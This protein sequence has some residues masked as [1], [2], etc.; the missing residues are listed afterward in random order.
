MNDD[1]TCIQLN[2]SESERFLNWLNQSNNF[3]FQTFSEKGK[4]GPAEQFSGTV[5]NLWSMLEFANMRQRGVAVTINETQGGRKGENVTRIRAVWQEDDNG[6]SGSFPLEPSIVV[7]S[8]V[9]KFHRYW[10]VDGDWPADDQGR[11]D[12]TAVMAT[13]VREYGS[14]PSAKDISRAM[15]LPGTLHQKGDPQIVSI[16][17]PVGS[18]PVRYTRQQIVSAFAGDETRPKPADAGRDTTKKAELEFDLARV[19]SA[20]SA[21][22]P[23]NH[24]QWKPTGMALHDAT[25]GSDDGLKIWTDWSMGTDRANFDMAEQI[26]QWRSFDLGKSVAVTLGTVFHNARLAG[27][28]NDPWAGA[29][30]SGT[31][32]LIPVAAPITSGTLAQATEASLREMSSRNPGFRPSTAQWLGLRDLAS[33]LEA[34]ANGTAEPLTYLSC[35]DP[36]VG[37]TQTVIRFTKALLR[38]P[39]HRDVAVLICVGRLEEIR[40]YVDSAG[41]NDTDYAVLVSDDPKNLTLKELGNQDRN[42][43]RVLFTTQQMLESRAKLRGSFSDISEFWFDDRPRRVRIWDEACL[44]ARPLAVDVSLIE[45]MT[46]AVKGQSVKLHAELKKLIRAIDDASD[47]S[48]VDV[49]D[50]EGSGVDVATALG[51]LSAE[52]RIIRDAMR[53][54]YLLSGKTVAVVK[55]GNNGSFVHYENTLPD[56]LKPYVVCDAS[57]RVRQTYPHWADGRGDL[58]ELQRATKDYSNLKVGLWQTSGSKSAWK[59]NASE[60][61]D[62]ITTTV[63]QEPDRSF[64]IVYHMQSTSVPIDI[65]AEIRSRAINPGRLEFVYWGSEDCRATNRFRDIDRVILAGTL[66]MDE[67]YYEAIAR[68]SRGVPSDSRLA[69]EHRRQIKLGEHCD[70]ILQAVCRGSVR[71]LVNG[72]CGDCKVY[73]IAAANSGIGQL[74]KEGVIFPGATV[75]DWNPVNKERSLTG[76][77]KAATDYVTDYFRFNPEGR[78]SVPHLRERVGVNDKDNFNKDVIR[79][80]DFIAHLESLGLKLLKQKGRAGSFIVPL[81]EAVFLEFISETGVK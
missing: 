33:R 49:P 51:I 44:P 62:G 2:Q 70:L 50:L 67:S 59:T 30:I 46:N 77:V 12:F 31:Q 52:K 8:S 54:L 64:L 42:A 45:G 13:M 63:D 68:L 26:R 9:G 4:P 47:D 60:L 75:E 1:Q 41:L 25:G 61:I 14:D 34:L 73:V 5:T 21:I 53:D 74:L 20:L 43:A 71:K 80:P 3:T 76:L 10:L 37:K 15:R 35:L 11:A 79:H 16:I 17:S 6:Y 48:F 32:G 72:R 7:Q 27:W 18:E 58:V 69:K 28:N 65:P 81:G 56:D 24:E 23:S 22:N 38:S 40:S 29:S 39:E 78:L 19:E 57:G 36:G 66:F 55:H